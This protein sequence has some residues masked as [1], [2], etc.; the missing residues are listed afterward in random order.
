[1]RLARSRVQ[2]GYVSQDATTG[3]PSGG[4]RFGGVVDSEEREQDEE[5]AGKAMRPVR[6]RL[7]TPFI[8]SSE[9]TTATGGGNAQGGGGV[10][11][12]DDT[13]GGEGGMRMARS[14]VQT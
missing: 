7:A 10:R 11:F 3:S 2:T 1:M 4:V 9:A 14:R 6:G 12:G 8:S 5:L 13:E